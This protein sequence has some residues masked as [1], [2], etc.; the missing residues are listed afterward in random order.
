MVEAAQITRY[1]RVKQ[2][3]DR[4]AKG[5][6]ADYDGHPEF[7]NLPL[8]EF[9]DVEIYGIRM[10]APAPPEAEPSASS[11]CHA[12]TGSRTD[13]VLLPRGYG[14]GARDKTK[15]PVRL[16]QRTTRRGAV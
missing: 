14:K 9:L 8:P 3:L 6:T 16:N 7:W 12:A 4:A 15:R 5:A 10:I 2:I 13:V 1:E 11:C